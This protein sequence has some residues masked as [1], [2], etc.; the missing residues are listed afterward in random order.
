MLDPMSMITAED[1]SGYYVC[2]MQRLMGQ[3]QASKLKD[4][5]TTS[6]GRLWMRSARFHAPFLLDEGAQAQTFVTLQRRVL[7]EIAPIMVDS[8]EQPLLRAPSVELSEASEWL[9]KE[10]AQVLSGAHQFSR[11]LCSYADWKTAREDKSSAELE[12]HV[13]SFSLIVRLKQLSKGSFRMNTSALCGVL[14]D[15]P[16]KDELQLRKGFDLPWQPA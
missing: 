6:D 3:L 2:T 1:A 15:G 10:Y 14:H 8:F 4:P 12:P 11:Y 7:E 16:E 5:I 9:L 13:C